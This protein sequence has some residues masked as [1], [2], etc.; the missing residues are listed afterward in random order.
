MLTPEEIQLVVTIRQQTAENA[1]KAIAEVKSENALILIHALD[2]RKT[3]KEAAK[4]QAD[5][6]FSTKEDN[7]EASTGKTTTDTNTEGAD[8]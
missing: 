5:T 3:V 1:I 7:N 2:E 6:L 8:T 4:K